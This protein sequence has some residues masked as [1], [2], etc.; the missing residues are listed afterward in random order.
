MSRRSRTVL[1]A[2]ERLILK[3]RSDDSVSEVERV[4]GI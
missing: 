2:S 4:A 3:P 1:P